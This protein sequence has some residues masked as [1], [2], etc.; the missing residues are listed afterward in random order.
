[1]GDLNESPESGAVYDNLKAKKKDVE[2]NLVNL[3]YGFVSNSVEGTSKYKGQWS[4]IDQVIVSS[5]LL[6]EPFRIEGLHI[7]DLPF[8]LEPDKTYSGKKPYRTYLGPQYHGGF[9]DHLPVKIVI[10]KE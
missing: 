8:L 6:E 2:A 9:S 5:S 1:M 4:I 7:I 10:R 3:S